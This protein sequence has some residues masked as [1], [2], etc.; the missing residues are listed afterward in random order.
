[1]PLEREEHVREATRRQ[2]LCAFIF[3]FEQLAKKSRKRTESEREGGR[4]GRA[5][6][7]LQRKKKRENEKKGDSG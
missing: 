6:S 2:H 5:V 1:M 3:P 4:E 7:T